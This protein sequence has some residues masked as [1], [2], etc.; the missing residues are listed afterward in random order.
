MSSRE[1]EDQ[2]EE[3]R[4]GQ[5]D[6]NNLLVAVGFPI[7]S[8]LDS[9]AS[10]QGGS[11]FLSGRETNNMD[12]SN[13]RNQGT[14]FVHHSFGH[15]EIYAVTTL[16]EEEKT[17]IVAL[18]STQIGTFDQS[19]AS[20]AVI[21]TGE[22]DLDEDELLTRELKRAAYGGYYVRD[23]T[24]D[25][26]FHPTSFPPQATIVAIGDHQ[27]ADLT[28]GA[29]HATFVGQDYAQLS[30][31]TLINAGLDRESSRNESDRHTIPDN[32]TAEAMVI[33]SAPFDCQDNIPD[34][35]VNGEARVMSGESSLS[36][37]AGNK[38]STNESEGFSSI[39][40]GR[41]MEKPSAVSGIES[42]TN[43]QHGTASQEAE[44]LGFREI[45]PSE[46][47]HETTHAELISQG[48][49]VAAADALVIDSNDR[50]PNR[51]YVG[52]STILYEGDTHDG[53]QAEVLGI[54][55]D[56][57]PNEFPNETHAHF[58]GQVTAA[59][60]E[61]FE[62]F[63]SEVVDPVYLYGAAR[64]HTM[65]EAEL[66]QTAT[67]ITDAR[68]ETPLRETAASAP[69]EAAESTFVSNHV[70]PNN[71]TVLPFASMPI[72]DYRDEAVVLCVSTGEERAS[73]WPEKVPV[74]HFN[75]NL[76]DVVQ[77]EVCQTPTRSMNHNNNRSDV[78]EFGCGGPSSS[79][80]AAMQQ[81]THSLARGTANVIGNI[82]GDTKPSFGGRRR[83]GE[84]D[85][86]DAVVPRTLLPWSVIPNSATNTWTATIQTN[87][88]AL[89]RSDRMSIAE[90]NK[91][92]RAFVLPTE[93]AAVAFARA[94]TPPRMKE[95]GPHCHICNS[96]F[97]L[98]RRPCHCR[99]C[100]VVVCKECSV[101]WPSKMI[102]DTYNI[103]KES[104]VNVC[105]SC[106]WLSSNF[107][108]ALLKGNQ[109]RAVALHATGNINLH[110]PFGNVKG[111]LL[112]PVH[113]A[114]LGGSLPLLKWLVDD[115][116]CPIKSLRVSGSR[117]YGGSYIPVVTSKGRSLLGIAL[118]NRN[119]D[120]VRYLV[121]EKG[122]ALAS[123]KDVTFE[124]L[125]RNLDRVLHLLPEDVGSSQ[126]DESVLLDLSDNTSPDPVS[127]HEFNEIQYRT[128]SEEARDLGAIPQPSEMHD[129]CIIC[130][131][132]KID[133]VATPCGHQVCCLKCSQQITRCPVCSSDCTFMRVFK[134]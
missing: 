46:F 13:T 113:S 63:S 20:A 94:W 4:D 89:E 129:D 24:D 18:A 85:N 134:P 71:A 73:A 83:S 102:P 98:L 120:I 88:N 48:S 123:E 52:D 108:L 41:L 106:D 66:N 122:V 92:L 79:Q 112:Y 50:H 55:E 8:E 59:H 82:F 56:V 19:A 14:P 40:S 72:E 30:T 127:R 15:E 35:K 99:N 28:L 39:I 132:S 130:C 12:S 65:N 74:N 26:E 104:S 128:M 84:T 111:E 77:V 22:E 86:A 2:A 45:H 93:K 118:E 34:W 31:D 110:A 58:V 131:D 53:Q 78:P 87:Q 101:N 109:D 32:D 125:L 121:V 23:T 47:P 97:A 114:V 1:E 43:N 91:S 62:R 105:G 69:M 44:V 10:S 119:V 38:L 16:V 3:H 76:D 80:R 124:M 11:T 64:E 103:K 33:D 90:A 60:S 70:S 25:Y 57:H 5:R 54:Q 133:C 36:A 67:L 96:K 6:G 29:V 81:I 9:S 100:G 42:R 61:S 115:N 17:E 116:S 7:D 75:Y 21:D 95:K 49:M 27:D 117:E 68:F 126:P 37:Y 51:A 107:R